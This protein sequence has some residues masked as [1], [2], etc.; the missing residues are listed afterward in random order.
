MMRIT[1]W[2]GSR[3]LS[4]PNF[5]LELCGRTF[6]LTVTEQLRRLEKKFQD[7]VQ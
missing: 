6:Y 7:G 3:L 2:H 5:Q 1:S 4:S